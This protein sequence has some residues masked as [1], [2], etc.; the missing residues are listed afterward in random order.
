VRSSNVKNESIQVKEENTGELLDNQSLRTHLWL[1]TALN[2]GATYKNTTRAGAWL[3]WHSTCL[4]HA[5]I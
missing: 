2:P 1:A 4:A 3:K 5:K